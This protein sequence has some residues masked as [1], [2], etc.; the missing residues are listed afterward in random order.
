MLAGRSECS[1]RGL[2]AC[3]QVVFFHRR[4][5]PGVP[6]IS[7][8]FRLYSLV[9]VD[10]ALCP[11][12]TVTRDIRTFDHRTVHIELTSVPPVLV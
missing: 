3:G 6:A 7:R 12:L 11:I 2:D 4:E 9:S 10:V 5:I 1:T 8:E